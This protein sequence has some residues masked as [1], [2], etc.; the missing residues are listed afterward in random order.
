MSVPKLRFSGFKEKWRHR[1]IA[2]IL[3]KVTHPVKVELNKMY[4]QIGIRSHGKGLFHKAPVL[5]VSLGDKRVFWLSEDLFVLNIVFA[6]EQAV[7][8]TSLSEKGMVASHRFPMYKPKDNLSNTD[9]IL[10]F[11]LTKK[12][13]HYLGLASPGG[14]GRNKTL[15][16]KTFEELEIVV[17]GVDE[18]FKIANFL[19]SVDE[20]IIQLTRKCDLLT[21]YKKA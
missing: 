16:Q 8:R 7:A 1:K 15:G 5:G 9:Y 6:W 17:P 11:F 3:Q 14:A 19:T 18:Q 21:Q 13:K 4:S 20:K 12:G 2:D 10:H